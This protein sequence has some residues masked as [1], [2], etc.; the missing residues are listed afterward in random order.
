MP[1]SRARRTIENLYRRFGFGLVAGVDEVGRGCLAGPVMAGAVVLNPARHI[2]GLADSKVLTA[3]A[4]D[5]LY[6]LICR[7]ATSLG[8]RRLQTPP[9]STDTTSIARRCAP[10]HG[11]WLS[12]RPNRTSCWWMPFASTDS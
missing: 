7:Q 9:R 12:W 11:P 10:W 1:R 3:A 4:R 5:R 6:E 2:P 8:G